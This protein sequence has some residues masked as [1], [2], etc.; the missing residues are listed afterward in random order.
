VDAIQIWYKIWHIYAL[1]SLNNIQT[2]FLVV[3]RKK[4]L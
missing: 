3:Q 4:N 2:L 1:S